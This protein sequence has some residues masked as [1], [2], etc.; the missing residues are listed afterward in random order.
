MST[1]AS[2]LPSE[3]EGYL[4]LKPVVR[5]QLKRAVADTTVEFWS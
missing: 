2:G 3:G 1:T 4:V 5:S